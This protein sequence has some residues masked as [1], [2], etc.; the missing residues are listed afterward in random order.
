MC[1][2][3]LEKDKRNNP[4]FTYQDISLM[5]MFDLQPRWTY[6]PTGSSIMKRDF[7]PVEYLHVC[8]TGC[9]MLKTLQCIMSHTDLTQ[10]MCIQIIFQPKYC[11]CLICFYQG[12]LFMYLTKL[13]VV[14]IQGLSGSKILKDNHKFT[15]N[16]FMLIFQVLTDKPVVE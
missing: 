4:Q 13:T 3:V 16:F 2:K 14:S 9:N 12:P 6:R 8:E 11:N 5:V 1:I 10:V 7:L 15:H